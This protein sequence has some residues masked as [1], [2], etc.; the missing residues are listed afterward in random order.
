MEPL[1]PTPPL[2]MGKFAASELIV[3]E[4]WAILKS[5]SELMWFPVLSSVLSLLAT[6]VLG[7][8]YFFF[9]LGG[10]VHALEGNPRG[11]DMTYAAL[12]VLYLVTFFIVNL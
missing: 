4:S 5:D 6:V 3:K 12:F 1:P 7:I 2:P 8:G 10:D 9:L 11:Q